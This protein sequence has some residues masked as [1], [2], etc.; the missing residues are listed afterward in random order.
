VWA[1]LPVVNVPTPVRYHPDGLSHFRPLGDNA[2]ISWVHTRLVC[3]MFARLVRS[4]WR[5][6]QAR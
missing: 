5:Y 6:R 4:S 1:G 2:R 3:G